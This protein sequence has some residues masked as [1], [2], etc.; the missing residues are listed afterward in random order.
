MPGRPAWASSQQR[1][2]SAATKTMPRVSRQRSKMEGL[3]LGAG[4]ED[5]PVHY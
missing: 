1:A 5:A 3:L 4:G 2:V